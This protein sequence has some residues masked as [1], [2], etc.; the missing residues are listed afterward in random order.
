M[1]LIR[2]FLFVNFE[3]DFVME[4]RSH[5]TEIRVVSPA[6]LPKKCEL[7]NKSQSLQLFK[8]LFLNLQAKKLN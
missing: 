4:L 3:L 7:L 5:G 8:Q 6:A 1:E 2:R